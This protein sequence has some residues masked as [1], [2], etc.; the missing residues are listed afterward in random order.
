[1][2]C[3]SFVLDKLPGKSFETQYMS[4]VGSRCMGK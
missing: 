4:E 1:M 2:N 3:V